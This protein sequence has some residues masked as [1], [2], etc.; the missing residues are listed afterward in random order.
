MTLETDLLLDRRRLKRRLSLWR[1]AAVVFLVS[2]LAA[3]LGGGAGWSHAHIARLSI[4]GVISEDRKLTEAIRDVADDKTVPAMIVAIDSPGGAVSGGEALHNAIAYVAAKKP[5]VAVMGGTAASAGYMVAVPA[6]RIFARE[7][8]LTGSIGVIL[9]TG[10]VSGLLDKLGI[11]AGALVSGPLK[12]QPSFTK[13]LSNQGR[14]VLQG[15]VMDM[16]DQFVG[17]VAA[18]RHMSA[19]AVRPLADGRAYTGRQA[20]QLGLIDQIGGEAEAIAWLE[21]EKKIPAGLPVRELRPAKTLADR[22]LGGDAGESLS[23]A[24][25][26][27][28]GSFLGSAGKTLL[29]QRVKLDEPMALWHPSVVGAGEAPAGPVIS[30]PSP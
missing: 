14:E 12:D 30:A 15:L 10:D 4:S 21:R 9:Q 1:A 3:A 18:G 7:A 6:A 17:M 8:T 29:S 11:N 13:P 22:A 27:A 28:L 19:D 23:N 24:A 26:E 25:I 5:V 2:A 20:L 16:Y